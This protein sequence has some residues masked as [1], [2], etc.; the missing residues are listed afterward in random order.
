[1]ILVF[2]VT[3]TVIEISRE[4][5]DPHLKPL[6]LCTLKVSGNSTQTVISN[7]H[8]NCHFLSLTQESALMSFDEL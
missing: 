5:W 3:Q 1:M 8:S 6:L 2:N 4:S 7:C